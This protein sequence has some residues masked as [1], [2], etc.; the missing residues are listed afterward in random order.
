M[1]K[2]ILTR[3]LPASGKSTWARNLVAQDP[4]FVRLN[5]DDFRQMLFGQ[6]V[7]D[8][9]G[10]S[11]VTAA[12]HGAIENALKAGFNVVVDDTNFFA[13]G[14]NAIMRIA[15]K[16]DAEVEFKDFT[17]V[18]LEECIRR[19]ELRREAGNSNFKSDAVGNAVIRGMHDR[20]LKGRKLPLPV[21]TLPEYELVPYAH[22]DNLPWAVIVDLDGTVAKMAGRSPYEWNRV[23][24][25]SPVEDVFVMVRAMQDAG[26]SILFT[27][28][29]DGSCREITETW[30]DQHYGEDRVW[31]LF[32]RKAGDQRA[33]WIVKA[34]IFDNEIRNKWNIRAVFD[35]RQQVVDMW[36]KL[37]LTV[38]QVAP[39]DF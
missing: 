3:G 38:A 19:D 13:R 16:Y 29:R 34:E 28:G 14:V 12:Q 30:L 9:Q 22:V 7:L 24:E 1:T 6:P 20:Y 15:A 27:S 21:P 10:E 18:P 2:I 31:G 35:D 36:R 26:H 32:M 39:G 5:R 17:H 25:D 4:T 37:G 8:S 33:D 11:M 23:G